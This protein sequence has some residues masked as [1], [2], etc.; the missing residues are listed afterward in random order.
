MRLGVLDV[1]SNT[2]HL[3][4]MDAHHGA[5]PLA[6]QSFKEEIRLAEYL[7]E[8]G[9]LSQEGIRTL[10]ATLTRLKNA[11]KDIKL[12]DMLAFATSAIRE[13]NNSEAV[14]EAVLENTGVDLQVLSGPD[15]ARFT[16]LAVRRWVGWSAGDVILLDIGGGSLEIATGYQENPSYSNSVMLG[17]NRMTR[18]FLSGDP[19]NEKSLNR[20][21]SHITETL[22]SL[23]SEVGDN[24][25][26]TAIGTSKTFRTLRRI[27]QNF[28]PELGG[29]LTHEGLKII[30]PKLSKMTHGQRAE[31]PGVS[32]SRARQIVA[33]AMVAEGAMSALGIEKINQC[34]WALREGIVLQRLDWLKS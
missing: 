21:R 5:A 25:N 16:F 9:D 11:A 32:S 22:Q 29:S 34:P 12:D 33:G 19:F 23:K 17:A 26:R 2:V 3:Q 27:Q 30:V 28:L 31:L 20:L 24:E 18:Q 15:E 1:G 6:F 14:L 10:L 13:A 7:T 8:S 4:I